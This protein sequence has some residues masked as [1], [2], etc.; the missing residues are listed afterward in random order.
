MDVIHNLQYGFGVAFSPENLMYCLIGAILG[1]FIGVLPG[2]N[3]I[4]VISML[5]PLTFKIH[6]TAAMIMLSGIYYGC[7]HSGA[8]C[9]I[10][11]NMPGEPSSLVICIDGHPMAR[12]GR[13]GPALSMAALS[14]FFAGCVCV[15]L[16]ALF[17]PPIAEAALKFQAPEYTAIVLLALVASSTIAGGSIVRTLGMAAIGILIGT[18]GTDSSTGTL[19]FTFGDPRLAE[20]VDFVALTVGMFVVA[21]IGYRLGAPEL[22]AKLDSAV[23]D[24]WPRLADL[25]ASLGPVLRGTAI[26]SVL[27]ILPGTGPLIASFASY[28]TEKQ[29]AKDPSRFGEGAIEGVAGPE[30]ADNAA[31][32]TH[33]IPMLTLG[34]PAGVIFALMM[35]AMQV[36]GIPPGPQILTDH[37]DLFWGLIA[38]MW[39]GNMMLLVLNL[40]LVGVWIRVLRTPYHLLYPAILVFS[41]IGVYSIRNQPFDIM[42]AAVAGAIGYGFRKLGCSPSPLI[43]GMILGPILEE[44]LRRS[45]ILSRGDPTVFFTRPLSLSIL[46]LTVA[47]VALFSLPAPRRRV[48]SS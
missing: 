1:T 33:F 25:K 43:L 30:A 36:H 47:L 24:L 4:I 45:M 32:L 11:L 21:E 23:L 34:I 27:G 9:A 37:P 39:I 12:K 44:N 5:L 10:M 48:K 7:H 18:I 38:S 41:S 13:A 42:I 31:A 16:I 19:R 8:T 28:A 6:A 20:G 14:S 3:P 17:S 35:G 40:P 2:M 29:L 22:R 46:V 26:G 15:V